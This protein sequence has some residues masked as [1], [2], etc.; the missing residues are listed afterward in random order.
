MSEKKIRKEMVAACKTLEANGLN[1]GA[2]G[3][4][5]V[6]SGNAMLITPTAV[7]Y[8]VIAPEMMARMV[9][10]SDEYEFEGPNA[11]SSE[12]RFHRDIL[13]AR[14]DINAVV[15][16]HA[17]YSTIL[18]IARKP[19]PAIHYMIAAFG[20]PDIRVAE[21]ARYGTQE[22]SEHIV[23]AMEGRAGCL[24]ANHG[25]VVGGANLTRALWLASELEALAHQYYHALGIGGGHVLSDAQIEETAKGFESYGVSEKKAT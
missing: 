15:H 10:D 11:P 3:N 25:M 6:R 9:I 14:P 17:P 20:G 4:V 18:A 12:W 2:S 16:T 22:L 7:A 19:I 5:S 13:R 21:Y 24:M 8:D 1:R 23:T